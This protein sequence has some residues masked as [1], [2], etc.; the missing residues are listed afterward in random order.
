MK[1]VDF[2]ANFVRTHPDAEWSKQQKMIID[3]QIQ[4]ARSFGMDPKI[5][6]HIKGEAR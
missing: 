5:Y 2:W 4:S 1:W 6:L 3:S